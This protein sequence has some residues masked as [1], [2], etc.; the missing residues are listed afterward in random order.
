MKAA[1]HTSCAGCLFTVQNTIMRKLST[2]LLACTLACPLIAQ[3]KPQDDANTLKNVVNTLKER[4]TLEGYL[5]LGYTY[6]D[7]E[8]NK[9]N[10]FDIKRAIL[11]ARGKITDRWSCYF[12]FSLANSPRI[13]EAYT[14]YHFL[15]GLS[16]RLGE[17]KTMYTIENPMSPSLLELINVNS[18]ATNYLA[19]YNGSDPL[20]GSHTGR[21][22]G[23]MIYGDLFKKLF[24]YKLAVMNGQGINLKDGNNQKDIV[25]NLLITPLK[26]F[27]FGGSFI[28]GKGHAVA[29]SAVNPDIRTGDNYTRNRWAVSA[30]L[31]T[32]PLDLRTE[33]LAGKDGKVKS[34]GYYATASIHVL[35]KLDV[36]ASYDY[37]NKNKATDNK[38]TNYVA[39]LQWWFYPK[40][41]LQVQYTYCNRYKAEKSNLLQTQ[42]QVRF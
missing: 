23:I 14:E 16:V 6:D 28:K 30:K 10:T 1:R 37:L 24:S 34:E 18:Q 33:Y 42:I 25:G 11:M 35:S 21:D 39:G 29:T 5:Q 32:K 22:L 40:C 2:F 38:Q 15:P 4:I 8:S 19:G 31:T 26:E 7:L 9:T 12:M 13:L 36:I 41:R 20:Y 27:S 3:E 17:F